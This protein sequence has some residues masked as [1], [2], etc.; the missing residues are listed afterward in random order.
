VII[1]KGSALLL[2]IILVLFNACKST[3]TNVNSAGNQEITDGF[4]RLVL[5]EK[6]GSFSLSYVPNSFSSLYEPLFISRN[7]KSSYMSISVNGRIYKLGRN[8][9]YRSKIERR[10]G[11]PAL[12][13]DSKIL[14]ITQVFTPVKTPNSQNANGIMI[15]TTVH[16][17]SNEDIMFGLR[18]LL[19]TELGE[20]RGMFPFVTENHIIMD[21]LLLD[22]SSEE[23]YWMSRGEIVSLMGSIVNPV[24]NNAA[25]PDFIHFANWKRLNDVPWK[26]RY[27]EGRSFT[28][29]PYSIND[30]AVCYYYEPTLLFSGRTNTYTIFLTTQDSDW[31]YP[32]EV[33]STA[34]Y[35]VRNLSERTVSIVTLNDTEL[36]EARRTNPNIERVTLPLLREI[37]HMFV[38]GDLV[39][40][41]QDIEEIEKIIYGN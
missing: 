10:N 13:F 21:E 37:L 19:D 33:E 35:I 39:L 28:Y 30:S 16:N 40:T 18:F 38:T 20:R 6:T 11:D 26:L 1:R 7:P 12:V 22:N 2:F 41:E 5:H 14:T 27:A 34:Q 8:F 24:D 3:E 23:R 4:V 29:Y 36:L 15:T 9:N 25:T 31:Y 32:P 17:K